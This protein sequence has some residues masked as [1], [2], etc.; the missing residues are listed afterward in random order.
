M[1]DRWRAALT[2]L[3]GVDTRALAALRIGLGTILVLDLGQRLTEVE[4]LYS[5]MGV[6]PRRALLEHVAGWDALS[7]YLV[8]GTTWWATALLVVQLALALALLVGWHSR[9]VCGLSWVLLAS[10]QTR[11]PLVL[12]GA[13]HLVRAMLFWGM[14]TPLGDRASVDRARSGRPPTDRTVLSW[15]TAALC[16]QVGLLYLMAGVLKDGAVWVTGDAVRDA[17]ELEVYTSRFG[18]WV[19]AQDSLTRAL[20]WSSLAIEW[21]AFPLLF[22]PG[23]QRLRTPTVVVLACMQLGF[24]TTMNLGLFP[25]TSVVVSLC[26]LPPRFWD[27]LWP[28][29]SFTLPGRAAPPESAPG[30]LG[31]AVCASVLCAVLFWNAKEVPGWDW[32]TPKALRKV[33]YTA[34]LDQRWGMFAPY[35]RKDDH[36]WVMPGTLRG[37][38][39]LDVWQLDEVTWDKP[40]VVSEMMP[41]HRWRRYMAGLYL[42]KNSD[43]RVYWGRWR[44]RSWNDDARGPQTLQRFE[45]WVV[46]E[47]TRWGRE[48]VIPERERLWRHNCFKK[49]S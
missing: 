13:D 22:L 33:M 47:R 17:L 29:T 11:N 20:T 27:R 45:M 36:Y 32:G 26:L 19:L 4:A 8:S 1:T 21:L 5:D 7:L 12:Q 49:K 25:P 14:F 2:P 46:E 39:E 10:L 15:G 18:L 31:T 30:R 3:L 34:R 41:S 44:C 37:G 43:L 6:L 38:D 9:L 23:L 42:R 28:R 35:P 48:P 40:E 16:L 24:G